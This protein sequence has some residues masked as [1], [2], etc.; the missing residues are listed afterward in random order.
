MT[1]AYIGLG[2]NMDSPRQHITTAIQSL[3]EIQSTRIVIVSSLYKSKPMGP[4]NQGDYIN[5][6]VQIETEM[7]PTELLDCLQAIENEHG[8]V[9]VEHWGPRTI[10]LDILMFGNEIIQND[11][12]TVPHP[13]ITNR[14]FVI[15]PLAE[16][17]PACV[18][19]EE[20][21]VSDLILRID[22][23]GLELLQ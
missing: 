16:I 14:P 1:I 4:Q 19:P 6:V 12:L 5:A 22:Q 7:G 17:D 20:G 18:I 15:V 9:R 2:S 23:D 3:G 10:D 8:R 11:R 13:E 21:L